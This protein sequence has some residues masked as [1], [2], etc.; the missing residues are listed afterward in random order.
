MEPDV[1]C[2]EWFEYRP[3][4][5]ID[6]QFIRH[7]SNAMQRHELTC[8]AEERRARWVLIEDQIHYE[9]SAIAQMMSFMSPFDLF[10]GYDY[11]VR[12]VKI[13]WMC[14]LDA[15]VEAKS[16][17]N[18]KLWNHEKYLEEVNEVIA[19]DPQISPGGV[20]YN[21]RVYNIN[22]R[23]RVLGALDQHDV[24]TGYAEAAGM[25]NPNETEYFSVK[26]AHR[27]PTCSHI[28]PGRMMDG[29]SL[30]NLSAAGT[31]EVE[32]AKTNRGVEIIDPQ[33]GHPIQFQRRPLNT[34]N[35]SRNVTGR[36]N[37]SNSDCDYIQVDGSSELLIRDVDGNRNRNR[38]NSFFNHI[39]VDRRSEFFHDAH[40]TGGNVP[41]GDNDPVFDAV[42]RLDSVFLPEMGVEAEISWIP[43]ETW[44]ERRPRNEIRVSRTVPRN[45]GR[46]VYN[47][48]SELHSITELDHD[49]HVIEPTSTG[50]NDG[51]HTPSFAFSINEDELNHSA[52]QNGL[53]Y[54]QNEPCVASLSSSSD[55]EQQTMRNSSPGQELTEEMP[56]ELSFDQQH[57][58][59]E[60]L[61]YQSS[62]IT[63][64]LFDVFVVDVEGDLEGERR[65]RSLVE[66]F[67]DDMNYK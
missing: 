34:T 66:Q 56:S 10:L 12:Y 42:S 2:D 59:T 64:D 37:G 25:N 11:Y 26:Q 28:Q 17:L 49:G 6:A 44:T 23:A 62:I 16:R 13:A 52:T 9:D 19:L 57:G 22:E 1:P 29:S 18:N 33:T 36:G 24:L 60:V 20:C 27:K 45:F 50:E 39:Q 53:R 51:S 47:F 32:L 4:D 55:D 54:L 14:G 7:A 48:R 15:M 43:Q 3:R 21:L 46:N 65:G 8:Q 30:G 38:R 67:D 63:P 35:N 58:S 31:N 5:E 61:N 41:T 40:G